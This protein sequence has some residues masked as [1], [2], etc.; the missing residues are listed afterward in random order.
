MEVIKRKILLENSIDRGNSP[1]WGVLTASTFYINIMLTQNIDD[2]GLFTDI[3]FISSNPPTN[4]PPDYSILIN[5]LN[6]SGITFPFMS[7]ILP[8][9]MTGI[10]GTTEVVTR[11]P[12]EIESDFYNFINF[13]ITGATDSKIE[14]VRSYDANLPFKP[15]FDIDKTTYINYNN[16]I[17]DGVSRVKTIGEPKQYVF[18]TKNDINLGTNNQIYGLQFSDYTGTTRKVSI[19][20]DISIIP[21]TTFRYVGEGNNETNTSLSA[22]TKE[23]YLFGITSPATVQSDVFIDRGTTSVMDMHLRMSEIKDLAQLVRYGNGFY[24]INKQ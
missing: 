24:K 14:N 20:G 12:S 4:T 18:D 21:L 23:E 7:G 10:T 1:T 5:K 22:L 6:L 2:M 15:G 16:V 3:N 19:D 17:I 13:S 8:A 11:L 9:P